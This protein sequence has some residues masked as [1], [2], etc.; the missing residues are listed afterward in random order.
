MNGDLCVDCRRPALPYSE[1]CSMCGGDL[2]ET[3]RFEV[4]AKWREE[5]QGM[6]EDRMDK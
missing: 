4:L 6:A 2:D 1:Y 5:M 3:D